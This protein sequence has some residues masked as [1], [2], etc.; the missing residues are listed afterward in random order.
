MDN[1]LL[2]RT[3]V[4]KCC[5]QFAE[6]GRIYFHYTENVY[7]FISKYMSNKIKYYQLNK[8]K[9]HLFILNPNTLLKSKYPKYFQ[10]S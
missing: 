7:D 6:E 9:L 1:V 5:L 3:D 2:S 8:K 10:R 4:E